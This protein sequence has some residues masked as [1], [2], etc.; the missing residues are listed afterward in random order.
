MLGVESRPAALMVAT[1]A[2]AEPEGNRLSGLF[3]RLL[4]GL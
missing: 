2:T 4:Q 3:Q 1:M